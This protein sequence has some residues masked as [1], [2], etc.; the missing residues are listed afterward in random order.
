MI[1][2]R[3]FITL[4]GAASA[5]PLA[6]RGQPPAKRTLIAV[7]VVNAATSVSP[8]INGFRQALQELGYWEGRDFDIAPRYGNGVQARLPALAEELVKLKPAVFV[9][10][11]V[12]ATFAA[13]EASTTIPI[14]C[15]SL[16][17]PVAL[18]L[19][20]SEARPGG[21][22]TGLLSTVDGLP[23]KQLTL[24]REAIPGAARI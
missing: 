17:N 4:L 5:S 9:T 20:A 11:S 15:I 3:D 18:G 19:A 12:P 23:G 13:K 2:R 6:A 16:T 8:R 10:G 21:Q 22:V 7:L 14:V 1:R 24:A